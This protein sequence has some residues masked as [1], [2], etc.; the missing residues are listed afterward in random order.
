ML[1]FTSGSRRQC[2]L[3]AKERVIQ[4]NGPFFKADTKETHNSTTSL[5]KDK[6]CVH[7][8]RAVF[9]M[10]LLVFVVEKLQSTRS[11]QYGGRHVI[12]YAEEIGA[13]STCYITK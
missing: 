12:E 6:R 7:V 2:A 1:G 9:T 5:S 3:V 4:W 10:P 8:A 13:N 11:L